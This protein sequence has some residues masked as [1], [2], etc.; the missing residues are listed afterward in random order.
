MLVRAK[1][2]RAV[3]NV[4]RKGV[5]VQV[6]GAYHMEWLPIFCFAVVVKI[7]VIGVWG[8]VVTY[9]VIKQDSMSQTST[10]VVLIFAESKKKKKKF[11]KG[12]SLDQS[13]KI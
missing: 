6:A 4:K 9:A 12:F 5:D 3:L 2:V 7:K 13:T 8:L 10:R 11:F 1:C